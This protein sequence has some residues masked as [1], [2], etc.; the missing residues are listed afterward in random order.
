MYIRNNNIIVINND[1]K[2]L[3]QI[4]SVIQLRKVR[5][6]KIEKEIIFIIFTSYY[7]LPSFYVLYFSG[8]R[9]QK[10]Y[11]CHGDPFLKRTRILTQLLVTSTQSQ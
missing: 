6:S 5:Q 4:A 11:S 2:H 3:L 8:D 9:L 1:C 10:S 7:V